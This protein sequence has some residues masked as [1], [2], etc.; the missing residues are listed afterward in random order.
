MYQEAWELFRERY[1]QFEIDCMPV[2][3]LMDSCLEEVRQR[4]EQTR[5]ELK[6]KHDVIELRDIPREQAK[7]EIEALFEKG[8]RLYY[9]SIALTEK[10]GLP[11]V[12]EICDELMKE[13]KIKVEEK[14]GG[15]EKYATQVAQ[16]K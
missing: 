6:K 15:I 8:E 12:V 4:V 10:L 5:L 11:L 13:G 9:S 2:L 16:D 7:K 14:K 3:N 1:K